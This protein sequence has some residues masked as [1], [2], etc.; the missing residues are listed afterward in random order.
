MT[1]FV[2]KTFK[3]IKPKYLVFSVFLFF[4]IQLNA[5]DSLQVNFDMARTFL[6]KRDE[7]CPVQISEISKA[8]NISHKFLLEHI[9]K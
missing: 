1:C 2:Q 6:A 5:Q 3:M 4:G 9:L 7:N 8:E